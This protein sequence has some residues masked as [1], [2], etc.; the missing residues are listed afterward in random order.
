MGALS[1]HIKVDNYSDFR[2][3]CGAACCLEMYISFHFTQGVLAIISSTRIGC[4]GTPVS[5]E[6]PSLGTFHRN[7][8]PSLSQAA[9]NPLLPWTI[10]DKHHCPSYTPTISNTTITAVFSLLSSIRFL[11]LHRTFRQHSIRRFHYIHSGHH[12]YDQAPSG[13]S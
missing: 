12:G 13:C 8:S 4:H 6:D 9:D 5:P 3:S 10:T 2:F 11:A 1:Q 7:S